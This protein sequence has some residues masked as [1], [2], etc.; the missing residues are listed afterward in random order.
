VKLVVEAR[1]AAVGIENGYIVPASGPADAVLSVRDGDLVPGLINA[2]DH[3]HRNHYGRLGAPPYANSYEW[4]DDIHIRFADTIAS[5][6]ALPRHEALSRGAW[7]N[8]LAGVTT[9]V[10]HDPWEPEFDDAF[11]VR[12][13]RLRHAHSLGTEPGLRGP[14]SETLTVHVAEGTDARSA[15]EIHEL[16]RRGLL[17]SELLAVHVVGADA[18]GVQRLRDRGAA[19]VWC[20]TSNM[21][22]FGQT[23]PAELV[24][25]GIDVLL[26]S[27]SLLTGA[28]SLLDELRCARAIGLLSDERLIDAVGR[29]AARRLG[30]PEPSLDEGAPADVIVLRR[31]LLDA[32]A[33]DVAL[34]IVAGVPRAGEWALAEHLG[35]WRAHASPAHNRWVIHGTPR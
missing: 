2:H 8:I 13:A 10:H 9:V 7:K 1:N 3:L 14:I 20:P 33:E 25:P 15:A 21:F 23:V 18:S 6:R 29:V 16:D 4:G 22:L 5:A 34:V 31:P 17:T 35:P 32:T 24:R 11:P 28:G 12:V 19:I 26:G 27:D 30:L